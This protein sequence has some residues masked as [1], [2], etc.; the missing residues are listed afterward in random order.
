MEDAI[1]FCFKRQITIQ[2][3]AQSDRELARNRFLFIRSRDDAQ[4]VELR[5]SIIALRQTEAHRHDVEL[6]RAPR[7][8]REPRGAGQAPG[9][10]LR[11]GLQARIS[12]KVV[13]FATQARMASIRA[14]RRC[15]NVAKS[16][17]PSAAGGSAI[18]GAISSALAVT[19]R[20]RRR[21]ILKHGRGFSSPLPLG[22]N[23]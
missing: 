7:R 12:S 21:M 18:A 22:C 15:L 11:S 10:A 9:L 17:V 13:A 6:I 2:L 8:C 5:P 16:R 1:Y 19:A 14:S 4:A 3:L 20:K 23:P